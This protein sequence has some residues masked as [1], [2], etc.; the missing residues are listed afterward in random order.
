MR[1]TAKRIGALLLVGLLAIGAPRATDAQGI[2]PR[3]SPLFAARATEPWSPTADSVHT[4][5]DVST[6]TILGG[7]AGALFSVLLAADSDGP[8]SH[9]TLT[10]TAIGAGLGLLYGLFGP[11]SPG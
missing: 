9:L 7:L 11:A 1:I 6:P 5:R 4:S 10:C 8:P 3:P 2:G